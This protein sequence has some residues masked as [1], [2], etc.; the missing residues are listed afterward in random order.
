[1]RHIGGLRKGYG[2]EDSPPLDTGQ[3]LGQLPCG[4]VLV[5]VIP[6]LL[7]TF[8]AFGGRYA[9]GG[10]HQKIIAKALAGPCV[11]GLPS[12]IETAYVLNLKINFRAQQGPLRAF[13]VFL[14]EQ[15]ERHIH[16]RRLVVV[17][18]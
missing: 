4:F 16:E 17:I 9:T 14:E 15:V 5:E 10:D 7:Q 11:Q 6:A 1:M 12:E 18:R 2:D 3:A 8:D 13:Q